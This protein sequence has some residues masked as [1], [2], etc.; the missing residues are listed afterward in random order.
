MFTITLVKKI[1]QY[2]TIQCLSSLLN[3]GIV[4]DDPN[5]SSVKTKVYNVFDKCE[6]NKIKFERSKTQLHIH[7]FLK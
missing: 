3:N 2:Y 6:N 4:I 1:L 7:S 5:V